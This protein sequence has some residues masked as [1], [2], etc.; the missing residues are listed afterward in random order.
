MPTQIRGL[1]LCAGAGGLE[2]G[3]GLALPGYRTV[4]YVER[5][6]AAIAVLKA[7]MRDRCLHRAPIFDDLRTFDG[8]AWR[9]RVELLSAGYPCQP[10]STCGNRRGFRD[11]RNLWPHVSRIIDQVRPEVVFLENVAAH[12]TLGFPLVARDLRLMGYPFAAGVFSSG[13]V[14]ARNERRRLFV[15][16]HSDRLQRRRPRALAD[17]AGSR[18]LAAGRTAGHAGDV[19]SCGG[20]LVVQDFAPGPLDFQGWRRLLN[21]YPELE[22]TLRRD[23]PGMAGWMDRQQ[24]AGNGVCSLAA[25]HAYASLSAALDGRPAG[26]V[27]RQTPAST[28]GRPGAR[29]L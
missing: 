17:W 8:R 25:A 7:R 16:A 11:E 15:L 6:Q 28:V 5:A 1:A 19:A 2:L 26:R 18:H 29:A 4:A 12:L 3:I 14:G 24:L 27:A 20:A 9:G 13:E 23:A 21:A 10:F 22:P